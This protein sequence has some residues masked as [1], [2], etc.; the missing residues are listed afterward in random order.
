MYYFFWEDIKVHILFKKGF[1][2]LSSLKIKT[3]NFIICGDKN[4]FIYL[5]VS[6]G[7]VIYKLQHFNYVLLSK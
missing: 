5:T 7:G 2:F 3:Y 4:K 1:T 6:S